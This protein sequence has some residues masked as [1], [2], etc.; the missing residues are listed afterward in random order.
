M[1]NVKIAEF[2]LLKHILGVSRLE[3][4]ESAARLRTTDKA[5]ERRV[6]EVSVVHDRVIETSRV[7]GDNDVHV[8][9]GRC[10]IWLHIE[11][12]LEI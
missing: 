11:Q 3:R 1:I 10:R 7:E 5:G 12:L 9:V 4:K 2:L 6:E 8:V